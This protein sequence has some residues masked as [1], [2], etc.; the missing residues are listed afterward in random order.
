MTLTRGYNFF[1]ESYIHDVEGK[2]PAVATL[3]VIAR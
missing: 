1:Y 3:S 2:F